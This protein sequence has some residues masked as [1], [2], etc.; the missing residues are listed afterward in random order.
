MSITDLKSHIKFAKSIR[1]EYS[2][3]ISTEQTCFYLDGKRLIHKSNPNDWA[4]APR[5]KKNV[6]KNL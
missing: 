2:R 1:R 5:G 3:G 6:D 4:R